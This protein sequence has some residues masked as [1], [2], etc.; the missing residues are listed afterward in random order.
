MDREE[1][2]AKVAELIKDVRI[3]MLTTIDPSGALVSR[4]MAVQE[5]E[6]DGDLWFFTELDSH[7]ADEVRGGGPANAAFAG[8]THWVSVSG[9]AEVVR[10]QA[11]IEELWG[12]AAQAWFPD[13]P[14]SPGVALI[15][16]EAESA[17]YWDSPG[18]RLATVLSLAKARVT[19]ERYDGGDN[20][21]VDLS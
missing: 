21:E 1:G 11:K 6:F 7:K 4:P 2:V 12:A 5:V 8:S 3:A 18:G 20:V 13:G 14:A 10:D 17:E 19:G 15:K 9:T 16:L